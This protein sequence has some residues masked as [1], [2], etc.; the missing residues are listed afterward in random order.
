MND[1]TP[2]GSGKGTGQHVYEYIRLLVAE[3]SYLDA[4]AEWQ[5]IDR[6]V[7]NLGVAPMDAKSYVVGAAATGGFATETMVRRVL[8][9]IARG[10]KARRGRIGKDSFDFMV[11]TAQ[12]LSRR[13]ISE[14]AAKAMVKAAC[15]KEDLRP[16]GRGPF[17]S[18]SWFRAPTAQPVPAE[19]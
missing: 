9:D 11:E 6:A 3:T 1:L 17:R 4:E 13:E 15:E 12:S 2:Q 14:D 5:L 19:A 7:F 10:L 16:R 8:A 18:R